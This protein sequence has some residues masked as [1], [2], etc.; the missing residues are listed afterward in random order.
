MSESNPEVVAHAASVALFCP[1]NDTAA[2]VLDFNETKQC[3]LFVLSFLGGNTNKIVRNLGFDV[4]TV[5]DCLSD[6]AVAFQSE[7]AFGP[8]VICHSHCAPNP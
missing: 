4:A 8:S 7:G 6:A 3:G 2:W 1:G 5:R